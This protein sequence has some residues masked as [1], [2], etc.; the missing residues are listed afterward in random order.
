MGIGTT[1]C[2][3]NIIIAANHEEERKRL[4]NGSRPRFYVEIFPNVGNIKTTEKAEKW[5]EAHRLKKDDNGHH[6]VSTAR[7]KRR[8]TRLGK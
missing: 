3:W 5:I 2:N 7:G 4:A 1:N 6:I 8:K